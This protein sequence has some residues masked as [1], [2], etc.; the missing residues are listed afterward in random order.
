MELNVE[1]SHNLL[2]YILPF[3][4]Y[5]NLSQLL[6]PELKLFYFLYSLNIQ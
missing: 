6:L 5:D 3:I 4:H 2:L 1:E